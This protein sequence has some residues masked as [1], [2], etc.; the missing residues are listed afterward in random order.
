MVIYLLFSDCTN[1]SESEI[2]LAIDKQIATEKSASDDISAMQSRIDDAE[3]GKAQKMQEIIILEDVILDLKRQNQTLTKATKAKVEKVKT[4]TSSEIAEN[5]IDRYNLPND[6]KTTLNGTEITD[7]IGR[8]VVSDLIVGESAISELKN[9]YAIVEKKDS[10]IEDKDKIIGI[11]DYQSKIKDT[12]LLKKDVVV[13]TL[14]DL[15][16]L[17]KKQVKKEKRNTTKWKIGTALTFFSSILYFV[18]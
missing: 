3:I 8:M 15:N 5:L 1:T 9:T 4:F 6:I 14:K 17:Y 12:M 11:V 18:R 2:N 7:T 13:N 16:L 10:I